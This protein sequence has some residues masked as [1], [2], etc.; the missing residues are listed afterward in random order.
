LQ[1]ILKGAVMDK[2]HSKQNKNVNNS[3][4]ILNPVAVLEYKPLSPAMRLTD[5]NG[6]KI[7]L[8]WNHKA[9]GDIALKRIS[10]IFSERYDGVSFE[11]FHTQHVGEAPKGWYENV[12][13][14]GVDGVIATTGD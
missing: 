13:A 11:W 2:H 4:L 3:L 12:K 10:E 14:S 9:R 5:L 6:K 1:K 7:G 8:Y